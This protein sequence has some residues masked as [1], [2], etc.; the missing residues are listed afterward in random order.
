MPYPNQPP[1]PFCYKPQS[2]CVCEIVSI[3]PA[4]VGQ[5]VKP[6]IDTSSRLVYKC[7]RCGQTTYSPL[8]SKP[9]MEAAKKI[10]NQYSDVVH[11]HECAVS[12]GQPLLGIADLVGIDYVTQ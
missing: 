10:A 6:L 8:K 5:P 7:R 1:C 9:D 3:T 4:K 12:Q 2:A 11:L